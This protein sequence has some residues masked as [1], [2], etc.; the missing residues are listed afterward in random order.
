MR[1]LAGTQLCSTWRISFVAAERHIDL[2]PTDN[3]KHLDAAVHACMLSSTPLDHH[4]R[5]RSRLNITPRAGA[6]SPHGEEA[7]RFDTSLVGQRAVNFSPRRKVRSSRQCSNSVPKHPYSSPYP[8]LF[9]PAN[10]TLGASQVPPGGSRQAPTAWTRRSTSRRSPPTCLTP[11]LASRRPARAAARPV[12]A[13]APSRTHTRNHRTNTSLP[14][15]YLPPCHLRH[16]PGPRTT[17]PALAESLPQVSPPPH[18]RWCPPPELDQPAKERL[19]GPA[20][21][22]RR[23]LVAVGRAFRAPKRV[24]VQAAACVACV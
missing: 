18:A 6:P 14:H 4:A 20:E 17:H 8:A 7:V 16:V 1:A 9:P 15:L 3:L 10:R 12:C 2:N 22:P 19:R 23:P 24:L 5:V 21:G 13:F 11:R